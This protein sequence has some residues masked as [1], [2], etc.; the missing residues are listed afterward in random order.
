[1]A[2]EKHRILE[3]DGLRAFAIMGVILF[4]AFDAPLMWAGVDMFFVLSGFLITGILIRRKEKGGSYFGYFYGRRARRILPPYLLLLTV[5]SLLFG[6]AWMKHWYWFAFF[7]TNIAS[8]L[9]QGG[10]SSLAPL[11]SLAVEEQFYLFWPLVVLV[12]SPRMLLRI[13]IALLVAVPILRGIATPWFPTYEAIYA[14]TPFRMDL[15]AAGAV[16]ACI[17]CWNRPLLD[18]VR[19]WPYVAL[20]AALGLFVV[21]AVFDPKFRTVANNVR[22]NVFIYVLTNII[23]ASLVVIALSG[24]GFICRILRFPVLRYIGQISYSMYLI[25]QTMFMVAGHVF[26]A[27]R[28]PIFGLGL[29]LT[30]GYATATWYGF[31]RRLLSTSTAPKP[32]RT[33]VEISA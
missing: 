13:S 2:D 12:A 22:S 8:V 23:S 10:N 33:T 14:L 28:L 11:W 26:P 25:H 27:Q 24:Q 19:Y 32:S 7:A 20:A 15:L 30:I 5:S 18:R 1:M 9:H 6:T 31:E 21:L 3:L 29:A 16:I 17:T 4:H